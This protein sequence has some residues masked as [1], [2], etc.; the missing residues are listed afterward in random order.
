M[1]RIDL[2]AGEAQDIRTVWDRVPRVGDA[3]LRL[4]DT[5]YDSGSLHPR[6]REAVRRRIAEINK[7]QLCL[8]V[9]FDGLESHGVD[10]EMYSNVAG[11][12]MW[13]GFAEKERV[14][15]EF[16]ERFAQN[17]L[18]MDDEFWERVRAEFSDDELLELGLS[19]GTW[20][21]QG[22]LTQV[23]GLDLACGLERAG[24]A[25]RVA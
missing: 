15:I 8:S 3:W 16:A 13:P 5:V 21:A 24:A 10:E 22:R 2:T 9:R 4:S 20:V 17:H 23:L 25:G 19:V 11:Y 14:A 18:S 6:L 1:S 12:R 7:C